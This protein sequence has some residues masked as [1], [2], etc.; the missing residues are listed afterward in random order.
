MQ[1]SVSNRA[2]ADHC[3]IGHELSYCEGW[4]RW[5][6]SD[7]KPGVRRSSIFKRVL[8][9]YYIDI[10]TTQQYN[11]TTSQQVK[12]HNI[13]ELVVMLFDVAKPPS[14]GFALAPTS[15]AEQAKGERGSGRG[16]GWLALLVLCIFCFYK[17][18]R[19]TYN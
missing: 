11:N 10:L 13:K 19:L 1:C 14:S 18:I 9:C 5:P 3:P 6:R 7:Q 12:R 4:T 15:G 16:P 2:K 17:K 8:S